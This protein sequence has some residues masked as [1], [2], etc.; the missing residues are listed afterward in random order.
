M[1]LNTKFGHKTT[2]IWPKCKI[3]AQKSEQDK[4]I[5]KFGPKY[6]IWGCK[7]IKSKTRL[8]V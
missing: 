8:D 5:L 6:K 2:K 7:K 1:G 3:W 4:K